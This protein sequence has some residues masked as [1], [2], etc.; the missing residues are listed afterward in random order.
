M[1]ETITQKAFHLVIADD[2]IRSFFFFLEDRRLN[3]HRD[4]SMRIE[5]LTQRMSIPASIND[6]AA[7]IFFN[8][9]CGNTDTIIQMD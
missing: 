1:D 6:L 7:D 4:R 8:D 9:A 2:L 3:T 5:V